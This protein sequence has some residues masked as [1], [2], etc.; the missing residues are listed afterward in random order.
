MTPASLCFLPSW[1]EAL[2]WECP[3]GS[4][5][6]RRQRI[7]STC[8]WGTSRLPT[9][10][11]SVS[12]SGE[13]WRPAPGRGGLQRAQKPARKLRVSSKEVRLKILPPPQNIPCRASQSVREMLAGAQAQNPKSRRLNVQKDGWQRSGFS[14]LP[15]PPEHTWE[16]GGLFG[17][18]SRFLSKGM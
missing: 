1:L 14:P 9:P 12:R 13:R 11:M 6:T 7:S 8:S 3:C 15:P 2:S 17:S 4:G 5:M 18:V 16:V 10:S